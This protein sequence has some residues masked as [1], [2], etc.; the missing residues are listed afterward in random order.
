MAWNCPVCGF[1]EKGTR[2]PSKCPVCGTPGKRFT[3]SDSA[4]SGASAQ[5][6]KEGVQLSDRDTT[7]KPSGGRWKCPVCG[8]VRSGDR[9]EE[10]CPVCGTAAERF[11]SLD[12]SPAATEE[13]EPAAIQEKPSQADQQERRWRC[14]VCG[15]V[16]TGPEPPEKC[17]VCGSDRSVFVEITAEKPKKPSQSVGQP[18][19]IDTVAAEKTAAQPS[20]SAWAQRFELLRQKM[21]EL[22]AHPISVH[23]PNGLLPIAVLF[24][25]LSMV[26]GSQALSKASFYNLV[27]VALAMPGVLFSGY[28]DW[29]KRFG[30]HMTPVFMIKM[31]CGA[32][33][34]AGS[35]LL[36]IWR[37]FS[38]GVASAGAGGRW[39]YL[40]VHLLLL[41]AAM[42]AGYQGGKL[43]LFPDASGDK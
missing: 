6:G 32:I 3:S 22:H 5:P 42:M 29:Q 11:V 9:S 39:A 36:V 25:L 8:Y 4:K 7:S 28:N 33:I 43:V 13:A 2:A 35:F 15:Y 1:S 27:V 37:L 17:P 18:T 30:G 20:L 38:P 34:T 21:V 12:G 16:H 41:A 26:F 40:F 31:T 23:I 14:T 19:T 10:R 24:L